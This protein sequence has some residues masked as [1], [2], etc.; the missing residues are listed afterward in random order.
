LSQR[1]DL[2]C[3]VRRIRARRCAIA[4]WHIDCS[5]FVAARSEET[6]GAKAAQTFR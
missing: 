4:H 3:G 5:F 1:G 2:H 6:S